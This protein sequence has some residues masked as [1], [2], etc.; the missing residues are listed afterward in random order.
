MAGE[1]HAR[2]FARYFVAEL[3]LLSD[4]C[5][6]VAV[7]PKLWVRNECCEQEPRVVEVSA[8]FLQLAQRYH[9]VRG[10]GRDART[11][12]YENT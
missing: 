3:T 1:A 7:H 4:Y 8:S 11:L 5:Q 9:F 2:T 10:S 6:I 12:V